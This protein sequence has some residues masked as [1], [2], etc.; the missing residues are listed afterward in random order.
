MAAPPLTSTPRW[1]SRAVAARTAAGVASTRAQGQ[2]TT[3]TARAG[4]KSIAGEAPVMIQRQIAGPFVPKND[5]GNGED[6]R[7][8][9]RA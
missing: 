4:N 3:S 7:Q 1:A 8:K 5:R 2:A 9:R 6:S